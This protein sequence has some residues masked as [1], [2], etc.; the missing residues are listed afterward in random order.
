MPTKRFEGRHALVTGATRGIGRAIAVQLAF[1]GAHVIALGRTQGALEEIDDEIK[2][3][4]GA[5]TL[6]KLDLRQGGDVDALGPSLFAR[7]PH[8][9]IL[10]ASAGVLGPLS[11]LGHISD[12][13][14]ADT[15]EVN[16]TANWRLIRTLDPLLR[17]AEAGRAVFLTS[18]A[19][20][21]PRAYW[22]PYV[23][24]KAAL[25]AL[26][27]SYAD[28]V[29]NTSLRVNLANPGATR[30]AMRAKAMPGEDPMTLPSAQEQAARIIDLVLPDV[31]ANGAVFDYARPRATSKATPVA[32]SQR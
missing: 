11:P 24:S 21:R 2:A 16:L 31:T 17:R 7:W 32:G 1:E 10:V 22:G 6:V 5:T 23:A 30:T 13:D 25:E 9:D 19:A 4:G 26:V 14:W 12:A 15:L 8:L 20:N 29:A 18:G 3:G 27:K 28:E